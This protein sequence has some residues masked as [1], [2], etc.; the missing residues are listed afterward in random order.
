MQ[1]RQILLDIPS[2][3]EVSDTEVKWALVSKLYEMGKLSLGQC[4]EYLG[5]S[6]RL[7]I[8]NLGNFGVSL[9]SPHIS[10]LLQDFNNA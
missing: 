2:F 3:W 10:D 7:F 4:T 8:E 1:I 6:K 5:V 9:F